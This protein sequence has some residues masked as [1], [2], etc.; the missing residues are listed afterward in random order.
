[1]ISTYIGD[2]LTIG[3]AS[4]HRA[5]SKYIFSNINNISSVLTD[6]NFMDNVQ[7]R[8]EYDFSAI[9]ASILE[10]YSYE[11]GFRIGDEPF[12]PGTMIVDQYDGDTFIQC[13][14]ADRWV[15]GITQS[16]P[17]MQNWMIPIYYNQTHH[18]IMILREVI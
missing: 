4:T 10:S 15:Q 8:S 16:G 7:S 2:A 12:I 5:K 14:Q 17:V 13:G 1:M 18:I 9:E 11:L 6:T 3:I